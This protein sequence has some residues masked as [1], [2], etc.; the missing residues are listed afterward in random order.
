MKTCYNI[1]VAMEVIVRPGGWADR[2]MAMGGK[3]LVDL[4]AKV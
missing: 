4:V 2:V 3:G 1:R